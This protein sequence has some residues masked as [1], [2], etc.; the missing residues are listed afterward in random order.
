MTYE[1]TAA[2][3]LQFVER[4]E[5]I[6]AEIAVLQGDKKDALAEAKAR[7]YSPQ[8]LKL[9]VKLIGPDREKLI[10]QQT[11]VELYQRAIMAE[12]GK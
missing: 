7:G 6:D 8:A 4:I 3:L 10:E 12:R 2:E 5:T 9:V 11:L 1:V